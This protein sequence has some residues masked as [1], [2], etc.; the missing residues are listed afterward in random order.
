MSSDFGTDVGQNTVQVG[1]NMTLKLAQLLADLVK[2]LVQSVAEN[3]SPENKLTREKLKEMR[4]DNEKRQYVQSLEGMGGFV[5]HAKLVEAGVPLS[6]IGLDGKVSEQ[7]FK[8]IREICERNNVI[9][10][11]VKMDGSE[12]LGEKPAWILECRT[13]DVERFKDCVNTFNKERRVNEINNDLKKYE[14]KGADNL[15]QKERLDRADLIEERDSIIRGYRYEMN[16]EQA[17]SVFNKAAGYEPIKCADF[18]E[19]LNRNTGRQLNKDITFIV[20]DMADPSKY[21]RC[22][23]YMDNFNG[24]NY[25]KT[26]YE[27]Y[28]GENLIM[29]ADDGRFDGRPNDYWI[30]QRETMR[31]AGGFSGELLRFDSME[32]YENFLRNVTIENEA[33]LGFIN[34]SN[35]NRDYAEI[36]N[37]LENQLNE[38][39]YEVQIG[40]I[41][42]QTEGRAI[43][44]VDIVN[45]ETG[46]K[47]NIDP[48]LPISLEKS[49]K[50]EYLVMGNQ[51]ALYKEMDKLKDELTIAKAEVKLYAEG[52]PE[53]EEAEAKV[54]EVNSAYAELKPIESN[55]L[56]QRHQINAAKIE[57][58]Q[59]NEQEQ[60]RDH[61]QD[62][63][64][65]AVKVIE[66]HEE[67]V[68]ELETKEQDMSD[69][70]GTI[71]SERVN[72]AE[73]K[74][75]DIV[76]R[77]VQKNHDISIDK[78]GVPLHED[79]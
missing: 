71:E 27:V 73:L 76:D 2:S 47:L 30:T 24:E 74:N 62:K 22:H 61:I 9:V 63:E 59:R 65:G 32:N 64:T 36:A 54:S 20:A 48:N 40:S 46:E 4:N 43:T 13:S 23:G 15:S 79:R 50:A 38:H 60:T 7:E 34:H 1:A 49:A 44:T 8:Q 14:E 18:S 58:T 17:L 69:W 51:V 37:K 28:K 45:K 12:T 56:E 42:N 16:D 29:K 70:R 78:K 41:A 39:G 35:E 53:R 72:D 26:D 11:G 3:N 6:N 75:K 5:E 57:Y 25:I 67:R 68:T 10:S 21:V 52:T 66:G 33:E 19:A 31:N 55:L 77:D